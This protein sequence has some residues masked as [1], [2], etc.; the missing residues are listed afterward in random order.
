MT[1]LSLQSTTVATRP[2]DHLQDGMVWV[3]DSKEIRPKESLT[4]LSVQ[5]QGTWQ[6]HD[7]FSVELRVIACNPE[8][9][10]SMSQMTN[11]PCG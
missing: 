9:L 7:I 3:S 1:W 8:F 5:V 6:V 11:Q 4:C 2:E 10:L